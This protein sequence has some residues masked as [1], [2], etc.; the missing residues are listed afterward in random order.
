MNKA[1][2]TDWNPDSPAFWQ[3]QGRALAQRNL[4]LSV[5][6]LVLSF[7]VWM[8]WSVLV[9]QL[10]AAGFE[11]SPNQLFWLAALPGLSGALLRIVYTLLA[12]VFGGRRWTALS[13]LSLSLPL[14]GLYLT[15]QNTDNVYP[16]FL[17]LALLTGMGGA[18]FTSS[19]SH[20]A[21]FYPQ[22][23]QKAILG[24][25]ASLANLGVAL[26]Q[27]L[28]PLL[29]HWLL[30]SGVSTQDSLRFT[31]LPWFI[32]L[33]LAAI[34]AWL[35]MNDLP[36]TPPSLTSHLRP[37]RK[38]Q[39]WLMSWLYL[40]S[41][42]SFIGFAAAFPLLAQLGWHGALPPEVV[43]AGPLSGALARWAG[44]RLMPPQ[45]ARMLLFG[46]LG[47]AACCLLIEWQFGRNGWAWPFYLTMLMLFLCTGLANAAT[48]HLMPNA[49]NSDA[50]QAVLAFAST[51]AALGA[52]VIPKSLG[53]AWAVWGD[54]AP[55]FWLFFCFFLSCA[56]L[57]LHLL[58]RPSARAH[59]V[60]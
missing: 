59:S 50:P 48:F 13:S 15:L 44:L 17:L 21:P 45:P 29:M 46:F 27:F 32:L 16:S 28:L 34:S 7:G 18:N 47:M 37:F 53:S 40:G 24:L 2:I 14:L 43:F 23:Q 25:H 42:G 26:V 36:C 57:S 9:V 38:R 1:P 41:F 3:V 49:N 30:L 56:L 51:I 5:A 54:P 60:H 58:P 35:G 6:N 22:Q 55:A 31:L 11:Y 39:N 8:V 10:P 19:L 33:T 52:F 4:A 12:P 20:L